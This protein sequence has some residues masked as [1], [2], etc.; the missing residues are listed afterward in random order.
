MRIRVGA[1]TDVGRVREHNEDA[2]LTQ[3]PVFAVAD[4]MG[5]H[6]AGEVASKIALDVIQDTD[7]ADGRDLAGAVREANR[8]VL[9]KAAEDKALA[10]MGTT[11][12]LLMA[13]DDQLRLAHVGDSRAYL[14]RDGELRM[15]TEDHTLVSRMVR[16]GKLTPE[17]AQI[18]PQRSILTRALGVEVEV[19]VDVGTHGVRPGDRILICSDGLTSMV[20]EDEIREILSTNDDPQSASDALVEAANA[21]GGQDN[22]TAVVLDFG[23]GE[24]APAAAPERGP[25]EPRRRWR[26]PV[27]WAVSILAL[28][29]GAFVGIRLYVNSQ[30]YVGVHEERVAL[31]RGIPTEILGYD[32]SSVEQ[33]TDLPSAEAVRLSV[34]REL[35][36]GIT[37]DSEEE[38]RTII[39]QIRRDLAEAQQPEPAPPADED[40]GKEKGTGSA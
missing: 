14:L 15:L 3:E 19:E 17:E 25:K 26:K 27:I 39:E 6:Q 30:W 29:I 11:L 33:E 9:D 5:G 37:A 1:A 22:I 31:Y 36:D 38:A 40:G 34:W 21:A 7:L 4:G 23:E 10:G 20:P 35:P 32:L 13:R 8:A 28:L 16:E 18:H 24:R 12:T 2:Y